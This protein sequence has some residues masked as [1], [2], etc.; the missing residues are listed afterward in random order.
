M[1]FRVS[2]TARPG[3]THSPQLLK[4][5]NLWGEHDLEAVRAAGWLRDQLER[6]AR[7]LPQRAV[8]RGV[9]RPAAILLCQA[10]RRGARTARAARRLGAAPEKLPQGSGVTHAEVPVRSFLQTLH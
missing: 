5:L 3:Q 9:I 10:A 6:T 8:W 7:S 1:W 2:G 4:I